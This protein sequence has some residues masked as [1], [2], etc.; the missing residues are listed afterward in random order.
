M[1]PTLLLRSSQRK[2]R[3]DGSD[4]LS[5]YESNRQAQRPKAPGRHLIQVT[6]AL[7]SGRPH[8]SRGTAA[9]RSNLACAHAAP[10][11]PGDRPA[12]HIV[13][14]HLSHNQIVK[15]LPVGQAAS[16]F[17]YRPSNRQGSNSTA[18]SSTERTREPVPC[19]FAVAGLGPS[20]R[21]AP[22]PGPLCSVPVPGGKNVNISV[23]HSLVKGQTQLGRKFFRF[24]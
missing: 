6:I 10:T 18:L 24:A 16:G 2:A 19:L 22:Q 21:P 15:D 17:T 20:A 14:C 9:L 11:S 23:D 1:N 7:T 8:P 13:R 3:R 5:S 4:P 12:R